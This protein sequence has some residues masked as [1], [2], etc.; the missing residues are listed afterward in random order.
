MLLNL[1]FFMFF[2]TITL[3]VFPNFFINIK[4]RKCFIFLWIIVYVFF[5]I[6]LTI[7]SVNIKNST[8]MFSFSKQ[9]PIFSLNLS[10]YNFI[11]NFILCFPLGSI[12]FYSFKQQKFLPPLLIG[13]I[14]AST[15]EF[16]QIIIPLGRCI[17]FYDIIFC[18]L[19]SNI[20]FY[21]TNFYNKF[22][23][24]ERFSLKP[25]LNC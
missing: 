11:I 25:L 15:I 17:D 23:K 21:I 10:L 20:S 16:F 7:L 24:K 18:A 6:P 13:F 14:F 5:T 3:V 19:S 22:I 9:Q 2:Y 4:N 1:H 12:C 8:I